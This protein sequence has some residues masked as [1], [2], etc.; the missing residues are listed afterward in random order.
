MGFAIYLGSYRNRKLEFYA[1]IKIESIEMIK[2][3][4]LF[5]F[6]VPN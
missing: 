5:I 3:Y 2:F 1:Q 4:Y 6:L